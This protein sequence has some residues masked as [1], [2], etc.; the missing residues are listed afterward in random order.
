MEMV[1]IIKP[2]L[3]MI[4]MVCSQ[5]VEYEEGSADDESLKEMVEVAVQRLY[6]ALNP[7]I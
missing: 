7:V 5:T 6:D 2:V 1:V 4:M 3:M